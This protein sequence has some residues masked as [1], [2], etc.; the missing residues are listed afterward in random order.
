M[1]TSRKLTTILLAQTLAF[2]FT[3]GKDLTRDLEMEVAPYSSYVTQR[4]G[5][6]P[7]QGRRLGEEDLF[8][9]E[10]RNDYFIQMEKLLNLDKVV[11]SWKSD[12]SRADRQRDLRKQLIAHANK[13]QAGHMKVI[14]RLGFEKKIQSL[15]INNVIYIEDLT[16]EQ[17]Q[18]IKRALYERG[19]VRSW[20][21]VAPRSSYDT[22]LKP[23]T[24]FR[25]DG[26]LPFD[27]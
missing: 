13:E 7:L 22:T 5:R 8:D 27:K 19:L 26:P 1:E 20:I 14:N 9:E 10:E 15:W 16:K 4:D 17:R 6:V 24:P 21:K 3:E 2:G 25:A 18:L 12:M 23:T 11:A